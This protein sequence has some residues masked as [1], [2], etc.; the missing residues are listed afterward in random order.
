[1]KRTTIGF[2]TIVMC[3]VVLMLTSCQQEGPAEKAGKKADQTVEESGKKIDKVENAAASLDD[4]A[5]TAQI[6]AAFINDPLL[7]VSAIEV[8]T[9]GGVVQLSGTVDSQISIDRA[10]EIAAGVQNVASVEN[11][12]VSK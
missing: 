9:T 2:F 7:K 11:N 4:A 10:Q 1:M 6:K 3:T 5:I 12:L 8:V